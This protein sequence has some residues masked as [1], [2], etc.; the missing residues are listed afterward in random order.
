MKIL[1]LILPALL[2]GV[3]V[4]TTNASESDALRALF[5]ESQSQ[6]R[7]VT[8]YVGGQQIAA[9]VVAVTEKY[10]IAKNQVQGTIVLRL[11]RI[12]GAAGHVNHPKR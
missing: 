5:Q 2:L 7:G 11:D 8:V 4:S 9:Q 10:L 12:D 3:L 6:Q 1:R